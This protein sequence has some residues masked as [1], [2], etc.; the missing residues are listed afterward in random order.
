ME[1]CDL[2]SLRHI[3]D[4]KKHGFEEGFIHVFI[5]Q[6]LQALDYLHNVKNIIHRDIKCGT[7]FFAF[8]L[9]FCVDARKHSCH[10]LWRLG[11]EDQ[12]CRLRHEYRR[13]SALKSQHARGISVLGGP[14]SN[15]AERTQLQGTCA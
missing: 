1:Y 13:E 4:K 15:H 6:V 3:L 9:F 8:L 10:E 7:S 14:G 5:S 12:D 11:R 2:G